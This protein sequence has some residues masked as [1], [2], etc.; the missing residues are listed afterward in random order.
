MS[1]HH[2]MNNSDPTDADVAAAPWPDPDL[3][4]AM[5]GSSMP[6]GIHQESISAPGQ[7][8]SANSE[9]PIFNAA[10]DI[11]DACPHHIDGSIYKP[12]SPAKPYVPGE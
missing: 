10:D 7:I 9:L 2:T 3:F 5:G 11:A 4:G 6:Q 8:F 1:Q 12:N